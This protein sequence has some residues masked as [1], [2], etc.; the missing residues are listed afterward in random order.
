MCAYLLYRQE[1]KMDKLTDAINTLA[2]LVNKLT[3]SEIKKEG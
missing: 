1:S 2:V 3:D